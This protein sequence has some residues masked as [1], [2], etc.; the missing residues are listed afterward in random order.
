MQIVDHSAAA[1]IEEVL[2]Q[3][4]IPSS[5]S[6]PSAYMGEGMLNSHA[7]AQFD[8]PLRGLLTFS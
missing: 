2:A 7:F 8:P 3:S 1:Q 4:A 5:S 6:L